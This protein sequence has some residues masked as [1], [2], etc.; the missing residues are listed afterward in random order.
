[1]KKIILITTLFISLDASAY[2]FKPFQ[3][4]SD[5]GS[6]VLIGMLALVFGVGL[7]F[8]FIGFLKNLFFPPDDN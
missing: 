7:I 2:T 4:N 3:D 8:S 5:S 6:W 1:M